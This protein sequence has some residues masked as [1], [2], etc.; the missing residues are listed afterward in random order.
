MARM[1]MPLWQNWQFADNFDERYLRMDY[2]AE[3][4]TPVQL[5]HTVKE[6]PYNYFDEKTYQIQSCYRRPFSI[7][8]RLK[9]M[10]LFIDFE[11]VMCFAKVFVN[12]QAAGEHKGGYTP[13]SV[14]ITQYV[15]YGD[16]EDNLLTVYVDS[17]E[18]P[19]IPP[20]GGAIDYLTYG[21]IYREVQLRAVPQRFI[22][23]IHAQPLG[24]SEK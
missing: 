11:G 2:G 17:T 10:R 4:F 23:S 13:F 15:H 24:I 19:D 3:H 7:P 5:P 12:G 1:L 18:R 16:T 6:V 8:E 22:E 14:D 20:F 21:G 9:G